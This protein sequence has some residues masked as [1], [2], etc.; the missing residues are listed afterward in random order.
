M[1]LKKI[2]IAGTVESSD[3][4]IVIEPTDKTGIEIY[5]Q[6]AVM[7]QFGRQIKELIEKTIKAKGVENALVRAVD[8]G[9]ID[10][11]IKARTETALYR[12]C[13]ITEYS[14]EE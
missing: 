5:L 6:S 1:E 13:G 9:A 11:V 7:K 2:G 10:Y 12:A 14:W 4:N 8:K 3:I